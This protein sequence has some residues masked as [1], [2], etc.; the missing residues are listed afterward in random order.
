MP[1]LHPGR[2]PERPA[3]GDAT[4]W[5]ARPAG[6]GLLAAEMRAMTRVLSGVPALPWVWVGV[7]GAEPPHRETGHGVHLQ[8]DGEGFAGALRCRLPLP[9]ANETFGAVLLQHV[10]DDRHGDTAAM[11][12]ECMRVLAPGGLLWM[13][14]LNPWSPYRARWWRSGLR[15]HGPGHWQARLRRAGFA[16]DSVSLQWL[17]PRWRME[18]SDAGVGAADR[19][20]AGLAIAV[21]KRVHAV[22][23]PNPLFKLRLQTGMLQVGLRREGLPLQGALERS[24][25][26]P[27]VKPIR[28]CSDPVV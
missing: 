27:G 3:N 6:Q 14:A 11:L 23:P 8:R 28:R 9:L 4:S 26:E 17:G 19:V 13:A 24:V 25:P 20:R 5:F 21:R 15:A 1:A 2:Q 16:V 12:D 18:H 22:V 7:A 10:L